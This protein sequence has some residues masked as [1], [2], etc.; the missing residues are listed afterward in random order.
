[1]ESFEEFFETTL[2]KE[3]GIQLAIIRLLS[4]A[5]QSI[6]EA[7]VGEG[8]NYSKLRSAVQTHVRLLAHMNMPVNTSILNALIQIDKLSAPQR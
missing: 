1:M 4:H 8:V 2:R 5:Y 3:P 7:A 6:H